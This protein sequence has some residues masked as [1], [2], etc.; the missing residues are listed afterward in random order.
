M[1]VI[2]PWSLCSLSS[3]PSRYESA[4]RKHFKSC[5]FLTF[6][7]YYL[8]DPNSK[9]NYS[10]THF[11]LRILCQCPRSYPR[12][13][14]WRRRNNYQALWTFSHPVVHG[15]SSRFDMKI[16]RNMCTNGIMYVMFCVRTL[17][18]TNSICSSVRY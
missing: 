1:Q 17:L 5:T 6:I 7:L 12:I 3:T 10:C 9:H 13:M 15:I 8:L 14:P 16:Y 11:L 18:T 4:I 2:N